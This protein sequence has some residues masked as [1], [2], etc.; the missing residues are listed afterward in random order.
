MNEKHGAS[1]DASNVSGTQLQLPDASHRPRLGDP[2]ES[3][4]QATRRAW[5]VSQLVEEDDSIS[6]DGD[7]GNVFLGQ[8]G[9][10]IERPV[11]RTGGSLLARCYPNDAIRRARAVRMSDEER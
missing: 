8:R 6:V 5:L 7:S 4:T 10:I 9:V 2:Q 11:H 1:S 3:L